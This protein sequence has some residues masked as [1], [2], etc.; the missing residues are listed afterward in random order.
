MIKYVAGYFGAALAFAAIDAVWLSTMASR[1]YRPLIGELLADQPN[2]KAAVA[3]YVIYLFGIMIFAVA[4]A[5]REGSWTRALILGGL[6][7]IV[8]Y[9]TYD[10]T[11]EATLRVWS[12]KLTVIDIL[13]GMSLTA[14]SATAGYFAAR[15]AEGRFG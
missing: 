15:W 7:G 1:L 8:C 11:N 6:L 10:L 3:F 2:F 14:T 13:W 5:L 12:T 4:P 9:A